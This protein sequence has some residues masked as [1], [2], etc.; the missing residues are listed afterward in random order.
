MKTRKGMYFVLMAEPVVVFAEDRAEALSE[1]R[2]RLR[3][4]QCTVHLDAFKDVNRAADAIQ[5]F[6]SAP[7]R[8]VDDGEEPE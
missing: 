6:L 5:A 2:Q 4:G 7:L 8:E 1:Y 3:S